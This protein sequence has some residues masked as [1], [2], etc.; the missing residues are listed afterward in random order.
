MKLIPL[1]TNK[2]VVRFNDGLE[3]FFSYQ[4]PVA[5]H[6]PTQGYMKTTTKWSVTTT[7]HINNWLHGADAELVSQ[8]YLNTLVK[9]D[10]V[11]V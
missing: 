8:D 9:D 2:N 7:K 3:V 11:N 1:G 5:A 4:T 6:V 10:H